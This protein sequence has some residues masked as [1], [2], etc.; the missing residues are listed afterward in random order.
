MFG[1]K[2]W[3]TTAAGVIGAIVA[4]GGMVGNY[5]DVLPPKYAAIAIGI[6]TLSTAIGNIM[7]KDKDVHSTKSEMTNA[8]I[9]QDA[10]EIRATVEK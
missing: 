4:V 5:A 6:G 10:K 9:E 2:N 1:I 3:K 8:T 7:A